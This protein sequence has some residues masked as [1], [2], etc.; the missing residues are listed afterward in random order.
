MPVISKQARLDEFLQRLREAP[1]ADSAQLAK[2]LI[3]DTLNR[4]EDELSG[5][6]FDPSA[7]RTDGRMYPAQEDS[8]AD[9][10]GHP[11]LVSYRHRAHE[12]IIG[13]NGAFEIREARTEAVIFSKAGADGKTLWD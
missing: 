7:W 4:V 9:V 1:C 8:A 3:D 5:V 10:T 2:Q 12:T 6:P 13:P 11:N